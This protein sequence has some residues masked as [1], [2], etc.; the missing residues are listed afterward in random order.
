MEFFRKTQGAISIFLVLILLPMLTVSSVF[1]DASKVNLGKALAESAGDL[2][3][4]TALTN[5]DTKL[6]DLYGLMATAQNTDDLFA[7][8]EDYYRTCITSSGVSEG[9]ANFYVEEIMNSLR[10]VDASNDTADLMNMELV[11]FA[12]KK[13]AD[14]DLANPTIIKKQVVDFMKYRAPINTGLSFVNSLKSFSTLSKQSELAEKKQQYYEAQQGVMENLKAAWGNIAIYNNTNIVKKP[15]Y[16]KNVNTQMKNYG[17]GTGNA[18]ESCYKNIN[19]WLV[20]DIYDA[21]NRVD[22]FCKIGGDVERKYTSPNG[23]TLT[24]TDL[25]T[26]YDQQGSPV[27]DVSVFASKYSKDNLPKVSEI[28]TTIG[29]VFQFYREARDA[30]EK[31]TFDKKAG[32]YDLQY[33]VKADRAGLDNYTKKMNSFYLY[34]NKLQAMMI[35]IEGYDLTEVKDDSG[36]VITSDSIKKT[37]YSTYDATAHTQ[38]YKISKWYDDATNLY[39]SEIQ[40]FGNRVSNFTESSGIASPIYTKNST[41]AISAASEIAKDINGYLT[42]LEDSSKALEEAIKCLEAAKK[43]VQEDMA[44]AKQ[45]WST[46]A[47]HESIKD[48]SLAKQDKAE[49]DQLDNYLTAENISKLIT[50]LTN[51]N[52]NIEAQIAELKKFKYNDKFIGELDDIN[53]LISCIETKRGA[54]ALKGVPVN[55]AQLENQA[56]TWWSTSWQSGDVKFDWVNQSGTQPDL[57]KDKLALYTYLYSHF[58]STTI[59]A[60]ETETS[61]S[62][63][64]E[65]ED[66]KNGK[67]VFDS[68]KSSAEE[69]S[70]GNAT[71]AEA[72]QAS[73]KAKDKNIKDNTVCTAALPSSLSNDSSE[74]PSGS[75][76]VSFAEDGNKNS[77]AGQSASSLGTMFDKDFLKSIADLGEDLRNK[78]YFADYVMSMFSFDTIEKEYVVEEHPG[79]PNYE[80]KEGDILSLTKSPISPANNYAYGAEVEYIIYGGGNT[81]NVAKAYGSIYAIRF[82][83]NLVYAFATSEIRDGAFAMATPISA[84]TLGIIPVPLIQAVIIIAL[85]CCESGIDLVEL[86]E[87]KAVPLYKSSKTWHC[88]ISGLVNTARDLAGQIVKPVALGLVDAGVNKLNAML[89]MTDEE[90]NKMI[91]GGTKEVEKAVGEAYDQIITENAN[92]AIQELTTLVNTAVENTRILNPGETYKQ[93]KADMKNWVVS[94][95][96]KWGKQQT[97]S[98]LPAVVKRE[99][100]NVIVN[101]SDIIDSLF[102]IVE[103]NVSQTEVGELL[104]NVST[105][106]NVP[107]SNLEV[108]GGLVME[109][110]EGIRNKIT[111]Q[112]SNG[113][114]QVT[115]VKNEAVKKVSESMKGGADKLKET[116]GSEIDKICGTSATGDKST[117]VASLCSFTYSDY[118]R[119]FLLIALYTSEENVVLRTADVIQVNMAQVKGDTTFSLVKS[120]T[121]VEITAEILVK[122]TFLALPLFAGVQKNPKDDTAWYTVTYTGIAGY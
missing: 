23:S 109:Y 121:Y 88:S 119:L 21:G 27:D 66:T 31:I 54:N 79:E 84:A 97:G 85:A 59:N 36:N 51:I 91:A 43:G 46:V 57:T 5:Y 18:V 40:V 56:N 42:S 13:Y 33:L 92:L 99:A 26:F 7:R 53:D 37:M 98:D 22:Y 74:T 4:N 82:G 69:N 122:P 48:T 86:Q 39:N 3:L 89:D 117:G 87:G 75:S 120:A 41:Y 16:L 45:N 114:A 96:D 103:S 28:K 73:A 118:L 12:A 83:F 78:L 9:E 112:I 32:D 34:Y 38:N 49:I 10:S 58:A 100:A 71:N 20:M 108:A 65:K 52:K 94:E 8:L 102:D 116:L 44:T 76:K 24:L 106:T 1:I 50:R 17:N 2:T 6:K 61:P 15:D 64:V 11:S 77:A 55:K 107:E 14:A 62:T 68:L 72:G 35:W 29:K 95:I 90:L 60:S 115:K 93:K 80:V 81:G 101:N 19:K 25:Y 47:D 63:T 110:I 111:N 30:A 113:S 70:A 104:T 67:N 105:V